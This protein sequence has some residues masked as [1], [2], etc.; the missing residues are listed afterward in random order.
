M[1]LLGQLSALFHRAAEP[2]TIPEC[3]N[4]KRLL[5]HDQIMHMLQDVNKRLKHLNKDVKADA[6]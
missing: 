1:H 3:R 2:L 5:S 6:L 4:T